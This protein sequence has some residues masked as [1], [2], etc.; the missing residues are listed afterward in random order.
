MVAQLQGGAEAHWQ[1]MQKRTFTRYINSKLKARNLVVG[2]LDHRAVLV[3]PLALQLRQQLLRWHHAGL[4]L[5]LLLRLAGASRE[6]SRDRI[7]APL[8]GASA[9][10]HW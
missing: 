3:L 10:R 4:R 2:D 1:V 9:L 7:E 8:G 5:L 6:L